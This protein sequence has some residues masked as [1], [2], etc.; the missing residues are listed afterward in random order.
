MDRRTFLKYSLATGVVIWAAEEIP[1]LLGMNDLQASSL[2][3]IQPA[4]A[5]T[6]T[7]PQ[8]VASGDPQPHGITLWTRVGM[9][10]L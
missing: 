1:K 4:N 8:S 5:A 10:I 6:G 7:F 9:V 3:A 2:F